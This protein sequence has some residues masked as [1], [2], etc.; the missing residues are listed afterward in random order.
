M[1]S[2]DLQMPTWYKDA[3]K[4]LAK[5]HKKGSTC[6]NKTQLFPQICTN[7]LPTRKIIAKLDYFHQYI[8]DDFHFRI[9]QGW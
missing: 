1:V 4:T 2:L 3:L 8:H 9:I 7:C 5:E 6:A